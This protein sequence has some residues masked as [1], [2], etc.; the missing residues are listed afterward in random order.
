VEAI[1]IRANNEQSASKKAQLFK[2]V[3]QIFEDGY[4]VTST[5][6]PQQFSNPASLMWCAASARDRAGD[7]DKANRDF[8]KFNQLCPG[9][10]AEHW[11]R[12][13]Y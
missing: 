4:R 9:N 7:E 2:R 1:L 10:A 8:E 11:K 5:E 6:K 3:A 12:P 13:L